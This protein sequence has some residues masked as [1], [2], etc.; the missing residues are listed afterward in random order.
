[1]AP[2][3]GFTSI[4]HTSVLDGLLEI[5][6]LDDEPASTWQPFQQDSQIFTFEFKLT[7]KGE[8]TLLEL[9]SDFFALA[10]DGPFPELDSH[11]GSTS[12]SEL[13]EAAFKRE[14]SR[15]NEILE[16][17]WSWEDVVSGTRENKLVSWD[18]FLQPECGRP[19]SAHSTE[20]NPA[21]F[22]PF[23]AIQVSQ[24]NIKLPKVVAPRQELL[25]SLFELAMGR[26]SVLFRFDHAKARFVSISD[27]L[28]LFGIGFATLQDALQKMQRTGNSMRH[29]EGFVAKS[30]TRPLSIALSSAISTVLNATRAELQA[31]KHNIQT[32]SQLEHFFARPGRLVHNLEDLV[33]CFTATD[34]EE[35]AITKLISKTER[36]TSSHSWL[37][38]LLHEVLGRTLAPWISTVEAKAGLGLGLPTSEAEA[39]TSFGSFETQG[40]GPEGNQETLLVPIGG[41]LIESRRCLAIL[42]DQQ[43]N[44][45]VLNKSRHISS[46]LSWEA[47]WEGIIR[48]QEQAN[49]Y[50]QRLK[51]AVLEYSHGNLTVPDYQTSGKNDC[52]LPKEDEGL[53]LIDLNLFDAFDRYLGERVSPLESTL[54]RLTTTALRTTTDSLDLLGRSD[55]YPPLSQ[56]LSLSLMP[57]LNTQSRLLSFSTLSLLF[58]T[59]SL[60]HHFS[61]QYRFQLLS[62]GPF[63]AR[64]TRALFDPD[65]TAG[66]GSTGLRLQARDIWPPASSELRLLLMGILGDSYHATNPFK[67]SRDAEMPGALSFA[68]R[69]LTVEELEKCKDSS[70]IEALDFLRLQYSPPPVLGSVISQTSLK[71]Y[72]KIFKHLLRLLRMR[73]LAQSLLR[74]VAGKAGKVDPETQRF[75][76]EIQNFV[77][78]LAAYS[79]DDAI[80]TAWM[81]FERSLQDIE[82]AIN[83]GDYEGTLAKA[84]SLSRL[85]CYHEEVLD[86]IIQGLFLDHHQAQVQELIEGIFELVL[87]FST[88]ITRRHDGHGV[89]KDWDGVKSIHMEFKK[90]VGQLVRYLRSQGDS[91]S[92]EEKHLVIDSDGDGNSDGISDSNSDGALLSSDGPPPFQH[93]LVKL[94]M[95]GFYS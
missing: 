6:D 4:G 27:D 60:R 80:D 66:E 24:G 33:K 32:I 23:L 30:K 90:Q 43:V 17:V 54:S 19:R 38:D 57:S 22:D 37:T 58:K 70:S 1:M 82:D 34:G 21:C 36:L 42:G 93:L 81:R 86:S 51:E 72:D 14:S 13:G 74:D 40:G 45:P 65:Q 7:E 12:L 41:L 3:R 16:H 29:L 64:L 79:H 2:D 69:D 91:A 18:T 59:H 71:K 73:A 8:E 87:R 63:A 76:I 11:V 50:E 95:F 61:L 31:S 62:D 39:L 55:L 49:E 68:L 84:G 85:A 83:R 52:Q 94:D 89:D 53:V 9:H 47:S 75:R 15:D 26:E 92:V 77:S 35:N 20:P 25:R 46:A 56:S 44:H 67:K 48:L 28:G 88:H 10:S 78:T 5:P